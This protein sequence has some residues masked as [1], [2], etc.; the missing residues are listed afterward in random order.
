[1]NRLFHAYPQS[2]VQPSTVVTLVLHP[3]GAECLILLLRSSAM[4]WGTRAMRGMSCSAARRGRVR[5]AESGLGPYPPV[6]VSWAAAVAP[7]AGV[8]LLLYLM[9]SIC[10]HVYTFTCLLCLLYVYIGV[11]ICIINQMTVSEFRVII[12]W[13]AIAMKV[14]L[15]HSVM[16]VGSMQLL[17]DVNAKWELRRGSVLGASF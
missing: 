7:V 5:S 17:F 9:Y 8:F 10:S 1:M 12:Q 3:T 15:T 13:H 2:C 16:C 6:G 4:S 11:N 14:W